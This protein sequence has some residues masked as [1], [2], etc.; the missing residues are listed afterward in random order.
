MAAI[1]KR[2]LHISK[3][4]P[5][6]DF[7]DLG[8]NS[9]LITRLVY[10]IENEMNVTLNMQT[11]LSSGTVRKACEAISKQKSGF[12][13]EDY[14]RNRDMLLSDI[15]LTVDI[16]PF[17]A[18]AAEPSEN[19]A[20]L[21]TGATGFVGA[22]LLA[23]LLRAY[24]E[25]NVICLVRAEDDKAA[26]KRV[27]D[28]LENYQIDHSSFNDRIRAVAGDI[29]K[30]HLGTDEETY[31]KLV[32]ETGCVFHCASHVNFVS[33]YTSLRTDN[34]SSVNRMISFCADTVKKELNYTP[35]FPLR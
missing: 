21:L 29:G 33:T 10:E 18:K 20:V 1:W 11:L 27:Y 12:T 25:R 14:I 9:L 13:E 16:K 22:F 17:L 35:I 19:S 34:I 3:V 2:V 6:D 30:D 28:N 23:E 4:G 32:S 24:P 5:D 26:L 15:K 31:K 8:G 7:F